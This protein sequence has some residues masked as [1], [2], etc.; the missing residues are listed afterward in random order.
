[1]SRPPWSATVTGL[2][3]AVGTTMPALITAP[4]AP[5]AEAVELRRGRGR[6]RRAAAAG[7]DDRPEQRHRDA[8]DC[9][10]ADEVTAGQPSRGELVDDVVS[11]ITLALAQAREPA[12]V[13]T[14][15]H[16]SLPASFMSPGHPRPGVGYRPFKLQRLLAS[17]FLTHLPG[18][19][20]R[21][22]FAGVPAVR[23]AGCGSGSGDP[24]LPRAAG[25]RWIRRCRWA[26]AAGTGCG[27]RSR[28]AGRPR[29][30]S[31]RQPDPRRTPAVERRHGGE[32]RLGVR[33]DAVRRRPSRTARPPSRGRG[34]APRS[35]PTGTGPGPGRAR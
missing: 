34:R 13:D 26:A 32:Q 30:V 31:P 9:A 10:A 6:R 15:C 16:R 20:G 14:P 5:V 22:Q 17:R 29:T 7:G 2:I 3:A 33:D 35:G 11:D 4:G 12:V 28:S 19:K 21:I 18:G 24:V 27:T 23:R 8:D 25:V 1:M